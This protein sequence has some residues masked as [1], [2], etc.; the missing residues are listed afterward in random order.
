[1]KIRNIK[2]FFF[3]YYIFFRYR[4]DEVVF[5]LPFL[6]M[7]RLLV[8]LNPVNWQKPSVLS[9]G[10]RIRL[11]LEKLGP[12]FV[13]FGQLLSTRPDLIPEDVVKELSLLQDAV[14]PF[15]SQKVK[16][17]LEETYQKPIQQLFKSFN[18]H[19]LASASVAQ[20]HEA[21]LWNDQD[22]VV[23]VLRPHIEK[24]IQDDIEL[25]LALANLSIKLHPEIER[26]KPREL[27][28]ELA[29]T[30]K[31]ELD[32]RR[33]SAN[34]AQLRR[35]FKNSALLYVPEVYWDYTQ[36]NCMVLERVYGTPIAQLEALRAQDVDFKLLA[37]R[38]IEIFFTQVFEHN[39]FHADMHPGN[40]F[41]TGSSKSP[42]YT[43]VD[44]GIVG[45]LSTQDQRYLA[46][47]LLAFFERDYRRVAELHLESGWIPDD[48]KIAEFEA[49]MRTVCEP[50]FE[51]P[52]GE[53]S[54][55]QVLMQ[56]IQ[57]AREFRIDIQP[58]L[59]LLQ[60]T[61]V[62]IEGLGR[63]LY[64]GLELWKT[65]KPFLDKWV[66][67]QIGPRAFFKNLRKNLP[68][69]AERFPDM[70]YLLHDALKAVAH[71]P[72][73]LPVQPPKSFFWRG[74]VLYVFGILS[75]IALVYLFVSH[76]SYD[77]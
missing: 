67:N 49:A 43:V 17:I 34:A 37:E 44:F 14:P 76:L 60:K 2:R 50:M 72:K 33:E 3:I 39:F 42:E 12:V 6:S 54:F 52:L 74:L 18:A 9:R 36:K 28:E 57:T 1:M 35:N 7:F 21:T 45:T 40:I 63:Q 73:P 70:P 62:N 59:I 25:M 61:L 38:G 46:E 13:K 19:P 23:K 56:L 10:K 77:F 66:K 4:L 68:Y 32:L 53:I 24:K 31:N 64:P 48:V 69:W 65:A 16:K 29:R 58:Q 71:P 55:G 22:V 47:N 15:S 8:Y 51:K 75:G 41:V 20:V 11:A 26:F 27:V 5:S 30:F